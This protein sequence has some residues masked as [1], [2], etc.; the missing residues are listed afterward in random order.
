MEIGATVPAAAAAVRA[1]LKK[2]GFV[3]AEK[4]LNDVAVIAAFRRNLRPLGSVLTHTGILVIFLGALAC[5]LWGSAG[6]VF[7]APGD[8]FRP[9]DLIRGGSSGLVRVEDFQIE[10]YPDGSPSQF[11][12]RLACDDGL[13]ARRAAVAVNS[14]VDLGGVKVFQSSWG[15]GVSLSVS[16]GSERTAAR[17]PE[18]GFISV[19]GTPYTVKIY[20]YIPNYGQ[21]SGAEQ[22]MQDPVNPRVVYSLYEGGRRIRVGLAELGRPVDLGD[23]GSVTPLC[24]LQLIQ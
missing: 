12:T 18:G 14:P 11:V 3:T 10:R 6:E 5:S 2:R 21:A 7:L 24:E 15:T 19:P 23:G 4:D 1:A 22:G 20:R 8:S 17:V 13:K 9:S 16:N